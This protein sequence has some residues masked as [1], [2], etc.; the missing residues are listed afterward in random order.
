MQSISQVALAQLSSLAQLF[1]ESEAR[2]HLN[3]FT[4][5]LLEPVCA[6]L[7]WED[8]GGHVDRMLREHVLRAAVEAEHAPATARAKQMFA[9]LRSGEEGVAANLRALVGIVVS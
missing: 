4:L 6:E 1:R 7:G 3:K 8:A 9:K 5:Q 2:E